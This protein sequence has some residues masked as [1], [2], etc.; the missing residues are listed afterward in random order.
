MRG[1]NISKVDSE[2]EKM[3]KKAQRPP[4]DT[5]FWGLWRGHA[6]FSQDTILLAQKKHCLVPC[7]KHFLILRC[8]N[9]LLI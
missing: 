5:F 8:C 2:A 4:P 6:I 3:F 7:S 9:D 1:P